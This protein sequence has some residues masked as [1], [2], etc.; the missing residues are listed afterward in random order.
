MAA[1]A[2]P[3][4]LD[5]TTREIDR[6]CRPVLAV[7]ELTLRCDQACR[8][9]GSR[10]GRARPDELSTAQALQLV[11]QL[12]QL[13]TQEVTLIGGEA[14][15]RDDWLDIARA[16]RLA[17]M[18]LTMVTGGRGLSAQRAEALREL[19]I[20][21]VSVSVDGHEPVHD[22][23]RG[24]RGSWRAAL[25]AIAH[26]RAVGIAP[27]A[28]TQICR[29]N[30]TGLEGM[31]VT[32]LD[33]GI[34]SW[35]VML[36]VP[37]GRAADDPTLILEPFQMIEVMPMVVRAQRV[38]QAR[39]GRLW[40]GNNLGYFG[41]HEHLLRGSMPRGHMAPCGAGRTA[42]GIEADGTVKGCPSLPT[43]AYAGGNVKTHTLQDIWERAP[44][45]RI[46]RGHTR[47]DLWGYCAGCY[48]ADHCRAGCTWTS[49]VVLGRA[50]NN[51]F[52]HHRSLEYLQQGVRERLR[53]V[54]PASGVPFDHGRFESFLEPWPPDELQ[55]ARE[56]V[57]TGEGWL[58]HTQRA[59]DRAPVPGPSQQ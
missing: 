47:P 10:A 9:C 38:L 27:S 3:V 30:L 56:L 24:V 57:A 34:Q 51:P 55:R 4:T 11:E 15:L 22:A 16:I 33:A 52:C 35:Q 44:A 28:N 46:T 39:G 42:L 23:L 58:L 36:T 6:H 59:H 29:P 17:G 1:P 5:D 53:H 49:H 12:A 40:P 26:L 18:D 25:D 7:W 20:T 2:A 8:H 14:Y 43:Q 41:P 32:L 48:Y 50:G 19:D 45:L 54:T 21:N 31:L 13:G 37:M